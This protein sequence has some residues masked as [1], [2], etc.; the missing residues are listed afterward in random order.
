MNNSDHFSNNAIESYLVGHQWALQV[1]AAGNSKDATEE[2]KIR[3]L[4]KAY[5]IQAFAGHFLSDLFSA[6]HVRNPRGFLEYTIA[7]LCDIPFMTGNSENTEEWYLFNYWAGLLALC[8]HQE[9]GE[10]GLEVD[11]EAN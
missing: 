11:S 8:Q 3:A 10:E 5:T 4:K 7:M 1:A 6:G 2:Q 9:D